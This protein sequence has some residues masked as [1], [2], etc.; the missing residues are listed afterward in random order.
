MNLISRIKKKVFALPIFKRI[1]YILNFNQE[2]IDE[3]ITKTVRKEIKSGSKI[4]DA[5]AG[6][7]RYK[8]HFI[9]CTYLTQDF[10][11]YKDPAGEFKYGKIDYVSD[12]LK[13]P[14]ENNSFDAI[15]CTEVFEHIP[16]PDLAIKEFSRILKDGGK[17]F[18]TAPLG[19]GVHQ[20]P[21]HYYGGFS[22]YW[23]KKY[24]KEYGF[25]NINILPKKHFFALYAIETLR[26]FGYLVKSK[27][28]LHRL[29]LPITLPALIIFPLIFFRLDDKRLDKDDF[30]TEFTIGYMV[31][32]VKAYK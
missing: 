30:L 32:A 29:L 16:R 9:D 31:S 26:A 20:A 25:N 23:Y 24:L 17:L 11:A 21:H 10:E 13:I 2:V 1:K 5:G 27:R 18:I 28:L 4:L 15:I 3:F 22:P 14:V 12:I 8:H 7:V 6:T 19:S